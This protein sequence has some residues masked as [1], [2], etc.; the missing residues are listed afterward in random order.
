MMPA[1]S[2]TTVRPHPLRGGGSTQNAVPVG[3]C[4][5]MNVGTLIT[6]AEGSP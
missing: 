2:V 1:A 6:I 5:T 4:A 3:P